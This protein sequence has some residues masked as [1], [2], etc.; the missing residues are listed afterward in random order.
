ME[1]VSVSNVYEQS[2]TGCFLH[3]IQLVG[4]L[5]FTNVFSSNTNGCW[6]EYVIALRPYVVV[7]E[8]IN[9]YRNLT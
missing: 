2:M 5:A 3:Y 7:M 6:N 1:Q 4:W 9:S 8:K